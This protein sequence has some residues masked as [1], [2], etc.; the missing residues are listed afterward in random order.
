MSNRCNFCEKLDG[1]DHMISDSTVNNP[2]IRMYSRNIKRIWRKNRMV[3]NIVL[4]IKDKTLLPDMCEMGLKDLL[5]D[6][7]PVPLL[8]CT[9]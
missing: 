4:W 8:V 2:I 7:Y 6:D 9:D 5:L 1:M 3:I